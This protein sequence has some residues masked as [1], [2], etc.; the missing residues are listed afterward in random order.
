MDMMCSNNDYEKIK[1]ILLQ[2]KGKANAITSKQISKAMG[3]PM[4][5]TQ[6][7]S[8]TAIKETEKR[9]NL[10]LL[11]CS[12][13]YFIAENDKEMKAYNANIQRRIDG[14]KKR[15]KMANENYQKWKK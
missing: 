6:V 10:P 5:D 14:M 3:F 11:S 13:G 4:E 9:F 2:H 1:D 7:V 12:K 8:R 15:R